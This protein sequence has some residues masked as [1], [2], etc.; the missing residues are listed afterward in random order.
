M[1]I[2]S[3]LLKIHSGN[4]A[5]LEKWMD[6]SLRTAL[7]PTTEG[8]RQQAFGPHSMLDEQCSFRPCQMWSKFP[9]SYVIKE[10]FRHLIKIS[11][12]YKLKEPCSYNRVEPKF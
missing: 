8:F 5:N 6:P 2:I 4:K 10:S 9:L 12:F 3:I 11:V 7:L 1:F